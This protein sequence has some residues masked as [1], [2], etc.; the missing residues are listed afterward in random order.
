MKESEWKKFKKIKQSSLQKFCDGV[1]TE[2]RFICDSKAQTAH[3]RY[4]E[5]Y[6]LI[7][8]RNKEMASAFD[9]LSRSKAFTQL[10]LMYRLGLVEESELDEFEDDTKNS[11][12]N[13]VKGIA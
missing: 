13:V 10:M 9:G 1:L 11:I 4:G 3:E 2:T 7:H 8:Q 5:L 12:R 6:D